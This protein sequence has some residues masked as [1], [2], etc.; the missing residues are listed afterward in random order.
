MRWGLTVLGCYHPSQQNTFT[1]RLTEPMLDAVLGRAAELAGLR[2]TDH[3]APVSQ[4]AEEAV[5]NTAQCGF[6][7]HPG[8][9]LRP[10][11][12]TVA[13]S[14]NPRNRVELVLLHVK[15]LAALLAALV[16]LVG[17]AAPAHAAPRLPRTARRGCTARA[18]SWST[19][20]AAW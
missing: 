7:P 2:H 5:L 20:T 8:H 9:R 4:S 17:L 6:D 12:P 15:R 3:R 10:R 19:S 18:G 16:V 13:P 14:S 1:G 11:S